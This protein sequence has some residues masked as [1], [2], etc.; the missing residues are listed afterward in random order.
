MKF[1]NITS[2]VKLYFCLKTTLKHCY[3][4]DAYLTANEV[5]KCCDCCHCPLAT[6]NLK[7][8]NA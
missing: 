6:V 8:Y 5:L 4:G 3:V 1:Y 2:L 7:V